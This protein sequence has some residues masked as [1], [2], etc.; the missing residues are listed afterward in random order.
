MV[1]NSRVSWRQRER[2]GS[3]PPWQLGAVPPLP[4]SPFVSFGGREGSQGSGARLPA[5]S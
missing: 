5:F 1:K 4:A 3:D 2:V